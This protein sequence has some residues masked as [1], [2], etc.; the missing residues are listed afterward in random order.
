MRGSFVGHV[1]Q[2]DTFGKKEKLIKYEMFLYYTTISNVPEKPKIIS[3]FHPYISC[4]QIVVVV[5]FDVSLFFYT[6]TKEGKIEIMT[7]ILKNNH[8]IRNLINETHH[9]FGVAELFHSSDSGFD[10][11]L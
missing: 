7:S 11:F 5:Q 3:L 1:L 10:H 2:P 9:I 4:E 6:F 8:L